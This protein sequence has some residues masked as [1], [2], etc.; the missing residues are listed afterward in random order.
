MACV[1]VLCCAA[2][3]SAQEWS[4]YRS[5]LFNFD[6]SYPQDWSV[7]EISGIVAFLSP[8][9]GPDDLFAENVNVVVEDISNY[10]FT[11]EEYAK[12]ADA[13]WI[14]TDASLHIQDFQKTSLCGEDA[15]YTI[16]SGAGLRYKQ[17]KLVV[18][19]RAYI[20]TYTA[21]EHAFEQFLPIADKIIHTFQI[22]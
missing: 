14:T 9:E 15:F 17:Y 4:T 2:C 12:A 18:Q 7:K 22:N 21:Q 16:V 13:Y 5:T 8:M 10:Q 3:T 11:T 6:I 20:L 1:F 19:S